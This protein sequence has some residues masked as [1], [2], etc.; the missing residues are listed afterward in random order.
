MNKS[1]LDR[2]LEQER[3]RAF[4]GAIRNGYGAKE[5]AQKGLE[6]FDRELNKQ[7]GD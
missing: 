7:M 1:A 3:S 2:K 5:A 6:A 4:F